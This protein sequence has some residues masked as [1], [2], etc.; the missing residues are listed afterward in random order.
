MY[1]CCKPVLNCANLMAWPSLF[2]L[3]QWISN[4]TWLAVP[5]ASAKSTCI[6]VTNAS[7]ASVACSLQWRKPTI[8]AEGF[9]PWD[10]IG[11]TFATVMALDST[12]LAQLKNNQMIK[13]ASVISD[14]NFIIWVSFNEKDSNLGNTW[15]RRHVDGS[16]PKNSLLP[17]RNTPMAAHQ[18][19]TAAC[20][21]SPII[22]LLKR[23]VH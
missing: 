1:Y 21:V 15:L 18:A 2:N 20:E 5:D 3:P 23:T 22:E 9:Q 8:A 17:L 6:P 12:N 14:F 7:L 13:L 16:A 4:G 11:A 19:L 10:V